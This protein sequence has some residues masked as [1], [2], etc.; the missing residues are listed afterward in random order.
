MPPSLNFKTLLTSRSYYNYVDACIRRRPVP[1][2][3]R[4]ELIDHRYFYELGNKGSYACGIAREAV[5][6]QLRLH[7]KNRFGNTALQSLDD[8][9][10]NE[11][12]VGFFIEQAIL[13]TIEFRGLQTEPEISQP[14]TMIPF[15]YFPVFNTSK[16]L[17]LYVP[18][19]FN[20]RAI[21][22]IILRLYTGTKKAILFPI[23][24]TIAKSHKKSEELFFNR[25]KE[26][27][28]GLKDFDIEIRFL[29]ISN[30]D[31]SH[32]NV[33]GRSREL[34]H[35]NVVI[36]PDYASRWIH[37]ENVNM[38]IWNRYSEAVENKMMPKPV[39]EELASGT[40]KEQ[41]DAEEQEVAEE[42]K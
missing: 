7:G 6:S 3:V 30:K 24:I 23:Q 34:R 10:N 40:S 19:D 22:G 25:W 29:W 41:R 4:P 9:I 15:E 26:W 27:K 13:Q 37:L 20:Y 8:Y 36:N 14:M 38:D 28:A 12:V 1:A 39:L 42:E 11:S 2:G 21:D 5:A 35:G 32:A 18:C 31:P 17:A 33:D 16:E